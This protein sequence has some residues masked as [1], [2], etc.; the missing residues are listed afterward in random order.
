MEIWFVGGWSHNP[1]GIYGC[2]LAVCKIS[3]RHQIVP[4][5]MGIRNHSTEYD[6]MNELTKSAALS[7]HNTSNAI[8]WYFIFILVANSLF[9]PHP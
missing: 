1:A 5:L 3:W 2:S 9:L 4:S 7:L 8:L 6:D